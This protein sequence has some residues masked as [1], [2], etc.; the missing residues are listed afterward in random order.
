V[1]DHRT[2]LDKIWAEWT[3][4]GPKSNPVGNLPA[5]LGDHLTFATVF[6]DESYPRRGIDEVYFAPSADR[7]EVRQPPL[8]VRQPD[9]FFVPLDLL[10]LVAVV[11]LLVVV[12]RRRKQR[13]AETIGR[14]P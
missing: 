14:L 3:A 13:R 7:A 8:V 2:G 12:R 11:I 4:E 6:V 10:V 9:D 1:S 5:G